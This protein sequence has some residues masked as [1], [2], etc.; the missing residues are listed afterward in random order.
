[1]TCAVVAV[2]VVVGGVVDSGGEGR[3]MTMLS[4]IQLSQTWSR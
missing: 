3:L 4:L 2:A 1:M